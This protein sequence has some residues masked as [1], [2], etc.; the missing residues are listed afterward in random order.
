MK[1]SLPG[2]SMTTYR[3]FKLEPELWLRNFDLPPYQKKFHV[4]VALG[5]VKFA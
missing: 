5:N 4:S 2:F 3:I 1:T